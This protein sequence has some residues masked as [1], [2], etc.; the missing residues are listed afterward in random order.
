MAIPCT[1]LFIA[2]SCNSRSSHGQYTRPST[3]HLKL[4]LT[5]YR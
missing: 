1:G 3:E 5:N 4:V 2:A